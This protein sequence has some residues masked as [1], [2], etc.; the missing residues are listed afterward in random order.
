MLDTLT[1][2]TTDKAVE[3]LIHI[4]KRKGPDGELSNETLCGKLWDHPVV[5]SKN[6]CPECEE[7]AKKEGHQWR[8]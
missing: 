7:V 1:E 4:V 2:K 6:I 8:A 5:T 3:L